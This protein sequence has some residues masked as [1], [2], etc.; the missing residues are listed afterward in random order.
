MTFVIEKKYTTEQENFW[1]QQFGLEYIN[2]NNGELFVT[3]KT[4]FFAE[5]LKVAPQVKSI[6][7]LGC[8]IGINLQ[9]LN[10]INNNFELTGY[11]INDV[12]AQKARELGCA[13]VIS[14]TIV[15]DLAKDKKYDLSFTSG[16]LIHINPDKLDV[17]YKN[18]YDLSNRYILVAE[19]YNPTPVMVKYRGNDDRLFKRDFAG[20]LID[21]YGLR[22]VDYGFTYHRDNYLKHDDINWFLLEK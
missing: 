15:E 21:R 1:S 12:A 20:E 16:V 11:E 8:N 2:R 3:A 5:I 6:V 17:V 7:E 19:Y 4:V 18:L 14:G 22:L 10:R 9:A 13:T